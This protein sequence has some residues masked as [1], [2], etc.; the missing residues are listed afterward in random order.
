MEIEDDANYERYLKRMKL[1]GKMSTQKYCW[2]K[3]IDITDLT[4]SKEVVDFDPS[5]TDHLKIAQEQE[6]R[7]SNRQRCL[8]EHVQDRVDDINRKQQA[9]KRGRDWLQNWVPVWPQLD[10]GYGE[11]YVADDLRQ[12]TGEGDYGHLEISTVRHFKGERAFWR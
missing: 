9:G 6:W 11:A 7:N 4:C 5:F 8:R 10:Q 1:K 3:N 2:L 12:K